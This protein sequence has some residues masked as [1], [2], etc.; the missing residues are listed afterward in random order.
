[1]DE[2]VSKFEQAVIDLIAKN[3]TIEPEWTGWSYGGAE[4]MLELHIKLGDTI[5]STSRVYINPVTNDH[6]Y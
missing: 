2:E 5:I 6:D 4:N 3:L 1:M